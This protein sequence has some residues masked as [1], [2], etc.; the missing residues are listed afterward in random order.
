MEWHGIGRLTVKNVISSKCQHLNIIPTYFT[1]LA[2]IRR[3]D[4]IFFFLVLFSSAL[5][6]CFTRFCRSTSGS[7]AFCLCSFLFYYFSVFSSCQRNTMC[8]DVG[9]ILWW[10]FSSL[11]LSFR[12]FFFL[13]SVFLLKALNLSRN[14]TRWNVLEKGRRQKHNRV[15]KKRN[16]VSIWNLLRRQRL[17]FFSFVNTNAKWDCNVK[18]HTR[19][20]QKHFLLKSLN[21][22]C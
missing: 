1:L 18:W 14:E 2:P 19:P 3:F 8:T 22:S 6:L 7:G 21:D 17:C 10:L 5:L 9:A 16:L 13:L 20:L 15:E 11:N 4:K 12:V